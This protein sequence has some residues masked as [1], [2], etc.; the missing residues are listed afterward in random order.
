MRAFFERGL[1]AAGVFI[2]IVIFMNLPSQAITWCHDYTLHI[3]TDKKE[4]P[5][6]TGPETLR[7][8]LKAMGYKSF[9]I[10]ADD[11]DEQYKEIVLKAGD[12]VILGGGSH[13]GVVNGG[14]LVDHYIQPVSPG[15]RIVIPADKIMEAS[16]LHTGW[17]LKRVYKMRWVEN[18]VSGEALPNPV[19]PYRGKPVEVWRKTT[20]PSPGAQIIEKRRKFSIGIPYIRTSAK[21]CELNIDVSPED[22]ENTEVV[23]VTLECWYVLDDILLNDRPHYLKEVTLSAKRP[24]S[25]VLR[26]RQVFSPEKPGEYQLHYRLRA[27]TYE[28]VEKSVLIKMGESDKEVE[29]KPAEG[30][31]RLR[32]FHVKARVP[33]LVGAGGSSKFWAM[34]ELLDFQGKKEIVPVTFNNCRTS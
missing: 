4:D 14:G 6:G 33:D 10:R 2:F 30:P 29:S 19:Y 25:T 12:V 34:A 3:I 20:D 1:L 7:A 32:K 28:T 5:N 23:P 27:P 17:T 15:K 18:P 21:E 8:R 24:D 9:M 31:A 11:L 26:F 16:G 22:L 13:S